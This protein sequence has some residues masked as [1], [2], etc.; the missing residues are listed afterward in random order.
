MPSVNPA[1]PPPAMV[2]V[3]AIHS[4]HEAVAEQ[5]SPVLAQLP[6]SAFWPERRKFVTAK[7]SAHA[8]N[9]IVPGDRIAT[10]ESD[11]FGCCKRKG[12][13][14]WFTCYEQFRSRRGQPQQGRQ[15]I[16]VKM[17]QE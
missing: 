9:S 12:R 6:F 4:R 14:A 8:Q 7:T 11:H 10:E 5:A 15:G 16:S 13:T 3:S 2:M 17:M 1:S